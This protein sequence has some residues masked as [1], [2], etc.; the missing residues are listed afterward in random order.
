MFILVDQSSCLSQI[1]CEGF[2]QVAGV[3][4][5]DTFAPVARHDTIRILLTLVGQMG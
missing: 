5:G 3:D 2:A 1:I 4:Y